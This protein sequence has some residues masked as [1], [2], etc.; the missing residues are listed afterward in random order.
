[1]TWQI[2]IYIFL[3]KSYSKSGEDANADPVIKNK[4]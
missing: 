3:K 4:N 2:Y 1:M